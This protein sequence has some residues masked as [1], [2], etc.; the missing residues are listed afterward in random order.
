MADPTQHGLELVD[1]I[2]RAHYNNPARPERVDAWYENIA[3]HVDY[4]VYALD[5]NSALEVVD[6]EVTVVGGGQW[7]RFN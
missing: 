5:D 3:R 1:F 6:T 2:M 4:P 7:K